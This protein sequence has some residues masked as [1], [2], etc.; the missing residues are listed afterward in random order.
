MKISRKMLVAVSAAATLVVSSA[1]V[2]CKNDDENEDKVINVAKNSASV[3]YDNSGASGTDDDTKEPVGNPSIRRFAVADVGSSLSGNDHYDSICKIEY[4]NAGVSPMGYI[5]GL[6]GEGSDDKPYNF[7]I[8]GVRVK[9]GTP[10]YY[11]SFLRGITG[12]KGTANMIEQANFGVGDNTSSDSSKFTGDEKNYE[13]DATSGYKDVPSSYKDTILKS[14]NLSVVVDIR[15]IADGSYRVAFYE[16]F[17]KALTDRKKDKEENQAG[18]DEA[19]ATVADTSRVYTNA[20]G[21]AD[22]VITV[23]A[24]VTNKVKETSKQNAAYQGALAYYVNVLPTTAVNGKWTVSD[25]DYAV[26][27][28]DEVVEE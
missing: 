27:A 10:Q 28:A 14:G 11:V 3:S 19:F 7:G 24:V 8:V 21:G 6:D 13:F 1:F 4:T 25:Q 2:G 5:F 18:K 12:S 22:G 9:G 15:A 16:D 20:I 23:P 26:T 17:E